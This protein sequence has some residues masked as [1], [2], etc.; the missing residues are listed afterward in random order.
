MAVVALLSKDS[1]VLF[2]TRSQKDGRFEFSSRVQ[3]GNYYLL[4][5]HPD[6][7]P[8]YRGIT[9]TDPISPQS[10]IV[11]L[12]PKSDSL[13]A[14]IVTPQILPP[15]IRGDTV[16]YNTSNILLRPHAVVE[17][18]LG[19]LP[20]LHIDAYGN[21]TY[22]GQQ[23]QKLLVDGEDM[24]GSSPTIVTKNFG[25]SMI[26]KV[27]V[28]E[29][30]SDK[31]TFTGIDDGN[32]TR[33][34]NLVLKEDS[35][36]GYFGKA[37]AGHDGNGVYAA[38]GF[39]GAFSNRQQFTVLGMAGNNGLLST[40]NNLSTPLSVF[41]PGGDPL[42]ASA[43]EGIPRIAGGG[44]HYANAWNGR[45]DHLVGNYQFGHS[46]T[47]PYQTVSTIQTLA[48]TLYV[49]N[50]NS[51]SVNNQDQHVLDLLYD[52]VPDSL[53]AWKFTFTGNHTLGKNELEGNGSGRFNADTV[54]NSLR[55]IRSDVDLTN[56][57]GNL[58][59][60]LRARHKARRVFSASAQWT[61]NS[62]TAS[63]YLYSLNR[64]SQQGSPQ[65]SDTTDQRKQIGNRNTVVTGSLNYTEPLRKDLSLALTYEFAYGNSE[66]LQN[67]YNRGDGKYQDY[68]GDLSSHYLNHTENQH[69]V[70]TL[71]GKK[72][73][74][75]YTATFSVFR[76]DYHQHDLL[77]DSLIHYGYTNY[78][79]RLIVR[80]N[81][82]K[83]TRLIFNYNASTQ[84]PS[85]SQLQPIRNN[86]DPLHLT[87][88]NPNLR[89]SLN[90]NFSAEINRF[91]TAFFD[92]SFNVG[93]VSNAIS[94][95]TITDSLGR[96]I[97]QPVN[98]D[99][100]R[101][102]ALNYSMGRKIAGMDMGINT[103]V[104]YSSTVNYVNDLL[105]RNDNYSTGGGFRISKSGA[106]KYTIELNAQFTYF[107]SR[108]SVNETASMHYWTMMHF[109]TLS[110]NFLNGFVLN[111][112]AIYT[113]QQ[114][115]SAFSKD[116]S[117]FFWNGSIS[118]GFIDNLLE[119]RI[120][121]FNMLNW[122]ATIF[123]NRVGNIDT[124][125]KGNVQGRSFLLVLAYR[126]DH[127]HRNK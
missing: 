107:D 79:P 87:L 118:H 126:F 60:R 61:T 83:A 15:Q 2:F 58:A 14:V 63:G 5:S 81:P 44:L 53:S 11:V 68:I 62:A 33:I 95:K 113:W 73:L 64:Y 57:M 86:D 98:V 31:A 121:A 72:D 65:N 36:H 108:S 9:I 119:V 92:L 18:M 13:E 66:S 6:Y 88:G 125:Q 78:A 7:D 38:S 89:P 84:Q 16:E 100:S 111:S 82:N 75:S 43:G 49:E 42:G 99:G 4:V 74:W 24:F 22:N 47:R 56:S 28:L 90:Q 29:R 80:Y 37:E 41:A 35:K 77:K 105:N 69:T 12:S 39:L 27:Q 46:S 104:N 54:N 34:L 97:S 109:A 55:I 20:G 112:S 110:I 19:K 101:N 103:V 21:I 116:I 94:V 85:I 59:W 120:Q 17:D 122:N 102:A 76:F 96:Q 26:A 117:T 123:R 127:K 32:R 25:A 115:A 51:S 45:E 23:I 71:Q 3:P 52:Y 114:A 30:K 1:I 50:Q 10:Y 124:E 8:Y 70:L 67:T 93:L 106:D 40:N 91:K 48:D